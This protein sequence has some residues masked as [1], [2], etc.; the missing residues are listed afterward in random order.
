L[1]AKEKKHLYILFISRIS[2]SI[3]CEYVEKCESACPAVKSR[4]FNC[5]KAVNK[6]WK[7][8]KKSVENYFSPCENKILQK[9]QEVRYEVC[10][11]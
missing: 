4:L 10:I 3:P 2:I 11:R 6:L 1:G 8:A 5:L 9:N 7:T